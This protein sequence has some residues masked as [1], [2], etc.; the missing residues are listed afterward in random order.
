MYKFGFIQLAACL[1]IAGAGINRLAGQ[2]LEPTSSA[3]QS[4]VIHI[5]LDN[6]AITP[7]TSHFVERSLELAERRGA[8]CLVIEMNTPGGLVES[9]QEIVTNIL[10]SEVPVVVYVSPAGGRAA[11]AGL[12]ITL[13]SHVAAMAP[14]TRIGAAHPISV[15][16]G[17]MPVPNQPPTPGSSPP[18]PESAPAP[19]ESQPSEGD[20][21]KG[22]S[23]KGESEPPSTPERPSASPTAASDKIINDTVAWARSLAQ[24]RDRNTEWVVTA[25]TESRSMTSNEALAAG[26]IDLEA[27]DLASLLDMIDG[28]EVAIQTPGGLQQ[29]QLKTVG[30]PVESFEMWWGERM[31]DTIANPNL[32]L[33]LMMVGVYGI[34]YE[35]YTPGWGVGGTVGAISLV[36]AFF[37][38]SVLP[39]N[40]AGLLLIVVALALLVAEAFVTS[41]GMLAAAGI[42]CLIFG[43]AMLVDSP[44]GFMRV[45]M[46]LLI[47]IA[48]GTGLIVVFLVSSVVKAQGSRVQTGG[49][50]MLGLRGFAQGPFH[51]A[52]DQYLGQVHVHGEIWNAQCD[53]P[54]K[55]GQTVEVANRQGLTLYVTAS[56]EP[57]ERSDT[58]TAR[59]DRVLPS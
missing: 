12:F 58:A 17:G 9:T 53:W 51:A 50:G 29:V 57:M 15:G 5:Q 32:A 23:A 39:I 41:Y 31:L 33:I 40:Y 56:E 47:P 36:L 28:R 18:L 59:A 22:D 11:S 49:E 38:L 2:E 14:G 4:P 48:V 45:S 13:S 6:Q 46:R 8:V 25:I 34:L 26:V 54:L 43:G 35:L 44:E 55:D 30:A 27:G 24:L 19:A 3:E 52:G 37:S 42:A 21:A 16:G 1:L 10:G 20:S 7:V